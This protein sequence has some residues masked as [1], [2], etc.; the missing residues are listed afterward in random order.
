MWLTQRYRAL[1]PIVRSTVGYALIHAI[2]ST[3]EQEA[4]SEEL[5]Q[6]F[7]GEKKGFIT[8]LAAAT[9]ESKYH[10]LYLKLLDPQPAWYKN[11]T[12]LGW[13]GSDS[14]GQMVHRGGPPSTWDD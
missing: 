9:S 1:P 10:F 11:F 12:E 4:M 7:P 8:A 2:S 14:A 6:R 5:W 3:K 13:E